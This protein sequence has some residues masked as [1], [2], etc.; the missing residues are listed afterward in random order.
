MSAIV[1]FIGKVL[2]VSIG[3]AIA[4]KLA[5]PVATP[6][7][8]AFVLSIVCFPSVLVAIAL[9]WRAVHHSDGQ[10]I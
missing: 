2:L 9:G 8:V 5:P 6:A 10:N 7:S 3:V 1:N 4:I